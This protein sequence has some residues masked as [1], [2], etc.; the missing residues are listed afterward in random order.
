MILALATHPSDQSSEFYLIMIAVVF[1]VAALW[2][3][4]L[5]TGTRSG[6]EPSDEITKTRAD[7]SSGDSG[8]SRAE[9]ILRSLDRRE[10]GVGVILPAAPREHRPHAERR[11]RSTPVS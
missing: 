10:A 4:V 1:G 7:D 11:R 9:M 6:R 8:P 3:A 2:F 5:R